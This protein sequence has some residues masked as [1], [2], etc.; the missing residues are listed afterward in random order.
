VSLYKHARGLITLQSHS[1]VVSL[2]GTCFHMRA[3]HLALK[4]L[5]YRVAREIDET[6]VRWNTKQWNL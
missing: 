6:I 2:S 4:G 5:I 1:L 3:R